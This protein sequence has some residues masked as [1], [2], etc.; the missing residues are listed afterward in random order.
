MAF[1][2]SNSFFPIFREGPPAL[3]AVRAPVIDTHKEIPG[4]GVSIHP[5]TKTRAILSDMI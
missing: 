2:S 3:R 4:I 1:Y 5:I